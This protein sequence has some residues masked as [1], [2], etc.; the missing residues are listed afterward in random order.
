MGARRI[1]FVHACTETACCANHP[2]LQESLHV[3]TRGRIKT[4]SGVQHA[5]LHKRSLWP[6]VADKGLFQ[7]AGSMIR[8]KGNKKTTLENVVNL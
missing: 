7:L 8:P 6:T 1:D 5:Y 2:H 4:V 3:V